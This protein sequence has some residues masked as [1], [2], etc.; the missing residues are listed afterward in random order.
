MI[1]NGHFHKDWQ[2]YIKMHFDQPMKKKRRHKMRAIRARQLAPRPAKGPLRPVVRCPTVR[3]NSKLRFG[4]GFTREELKVAGINRDFA[5]TIGI[6]VDHRRRNRSVESL[7]VNVQRL[8]E[9][10]SKLILFPRRP[11][12]PKK[13][14]AT[15]EEVKTAKQLKGTLMRIRPVQK[16]EKARVITEDEKKFSAF[17]ALRQARAHARLFGIRQKRAKEAAENEADPN[18]VVGDKKG[19]GGKKK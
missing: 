4:R 7:Q 13:G 15:A 8:R 19:G 16:H 3:Y 18:K 10:K 14:E 2:R 9:Y 12:K 17:T 5:K 11:N 6:S 1:P